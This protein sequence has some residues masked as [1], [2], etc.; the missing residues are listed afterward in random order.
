[1]DRPSSNSSTL[2]SSATDVR[3]R[4]H[5]KRSF[6]GDILQEANV[7]VETELSRTTGRRPHLPRVDVEC[8]KARFTATIEASRA[9]NARRDAFEALFD[10]A[11]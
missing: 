6:E 3:R 1:M 7:T 5:P 4:T 2:P 9:H 8:D 10:A 11:K